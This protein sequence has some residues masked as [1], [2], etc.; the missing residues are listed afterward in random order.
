MVVIM[1]MITSVHLFPALDTKSIAAAPSHE[2][3]P[4]LVNLLLS[5]LFPS[6]FYGARPGQR[7]GTSDNDPRFHSI[8]LYIFPTAF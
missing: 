5:L 7:N 3:F 2:H 1:M 6:S 8:L 4:F